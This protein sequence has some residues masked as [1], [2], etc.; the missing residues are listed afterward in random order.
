MT[1]EQ[2]CAALAKL[3][4]WWCVS[5]EN[6]NGSPKTGPC[7]VPPTEPPGADGLEILQ[8]V[9]NYDSYD[10]L[11]PMIAKTCNETDWVKFSTHLLDVCQYPP[12]QRNV[13]YGIQMSFR[14]S[15]AQLREAILR[16]HNLWT[17]QPKQ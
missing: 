5:L 6:P 9:P 10:V 8:R 3:D 2:Q 16:A 15:P 1:T 14:A 7:G 13:I 4:G 17:E 11:I 12:H